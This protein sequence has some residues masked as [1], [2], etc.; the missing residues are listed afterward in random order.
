MINYF[1]KDLYMKTRSSLTRRKFLLSSGLALSGTIVSHIPGSAYGEAVK[2]IRVALVGTGM[3]GTLFWL[4]K[5]PEILGERVEFVGLCDINAGR[6]DYS[7]QYSGLQCAT[8]TDFDKMMHSV[9]PDYVIVST[10]D[11]NHDEFIIRAMQLGSDVI[12]EKPMAT[13]EIKCAHILAAE[14]KYKKKVI[15]GFNARYGSVF[16]KI[17][18]LLTE[19]KIGQ[20]TSV[21]F[22]E[23][24]DTTHGASYFRRW[25]GEKKYSGTLLLQKSSHHFDLLNWCLDSDPVEVMAFGSLDFYGGANEFR[26]NNCRTCTHKKTCGFYWDI[27]SS[28]TDVGMYVNNEKQDG[29]IRD[30]C[31]YRKSIDIYDKMSVQIRYAN[32]VIVNYSLTTYSPYEGWQ[33]GF[34]GVKG[35]LDAA[36]NIP[37]LPSDTGNDQIIFSSLNDKREDIIVPHKPGSHGGADQEMLKDIFTNKT[38]S[39]KTAGTRDGALSLLIGV[40]ARKSIETGKLIKIKDLT[41]IPLFARRPI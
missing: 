14:K 31:L 34:N 1:K 13:D 39:Q 4:K 41:D 24:L 11:S 12:T 38:R 35:R 19:K 28:A 40:A 27:N 3:R 18:E 5:V 7:K 29:Y 22:H 36:K 32:N 2:K 6:L 37:W 33:I 21:D 17:K 8:F 16:S 25:H 20:V 15:V 10:I 9:K 30:N 23:Y 26:G